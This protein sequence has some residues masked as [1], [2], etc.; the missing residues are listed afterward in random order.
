MQPESVVHEVE[1][2]VRRDEGD[3]AVVLET[4]EAHALVELDVLKLHRLIEG[5][6]REE[7]NTVGCCG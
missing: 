1:L 3:G 4:R 5:R 6:E 2:S 7:G